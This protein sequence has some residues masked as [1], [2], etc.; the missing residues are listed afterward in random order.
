MLLRSQKYILILLVGIQNEGVNP[1]R[2]RLGRVTVAISSLKSR[3]IGA[4]A[5]AQLSAVRESQGKKVSNL[6]VLPGTPAWFQKPLTGRT[7]PGP[8][9]LQKG[10][11]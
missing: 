4:Q 9:K 8:R 7:S 10:G 11:G 6:G 2:R 1:F 3:H 5:G